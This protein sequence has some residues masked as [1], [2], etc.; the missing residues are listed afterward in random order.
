[1]IKIGIG[2]G[3]RYFTA[4]SAAGRRVYAFPAY[5]DCSTSS[6]N[7]YIYYSDTPTL[8]LGTVLYGDAQL[9]EPYQEAT[10]ILKELSL[11]N[12]VSVTTNSLGVIYGFSRCYTQYTLYYA[13]GNGGGSGFFYTRHNDVLA[14]GTVL[15]TDDGL[16]IPLNGPVLYLGDVR[17]LTT[18][19]GVI[20]AVTYCTTS[21]TLYP[22]C[23]DYYDS[24]NSFTVYVRS[25]DYT[26]PI[27]NGTKLYSDSD[28]LMEIS[29][30]SFVENGLAYIYQNGSGTSTNG[31]CYPPVPPTPPPPT[32]PPPTPPPTPPP[33]TPP[34]TPS[35]T[36]SP[37]PPPTP[38]P[39]P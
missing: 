27:T 8:A 25:S 33:P 24:Q 35:P 4:A 32:P 13:C 26:T 36:P 22:G 3:S 17:Y 16:T 21:L 7:G 18:S 5:S 9:T 12:G 29:S 14:N 30:R 20:S 38:S 37:T 28:G 23:N 15:Y 19:E 39:T 1:M 11:D 6:T 10:T 2:L 34:P 31:P